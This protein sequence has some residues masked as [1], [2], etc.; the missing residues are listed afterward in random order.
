MIKQPIKPT[1]PSTL[2][3]CN[4][5]IPGHRASVAG[6]YEELLKSM[7]PGQAIKCTPAQVGS[8]AG[9][10]RKY[11][12]NNNMAAMVKTIRNYGNGNARVWMLD[13]E[14]KTGDA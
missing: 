2:S 11:I 14:K 9:A 3:I 13:A 8:V 6:K 7:K 5:P 4:D 1:D 10:M 12:E